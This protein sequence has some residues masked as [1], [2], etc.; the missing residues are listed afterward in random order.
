MNKKIDIYTKRKFIP[1]GCKIT[2]EYFCSTTQSKT[3]KEAKQKVCVKYS[4][5]GT[6]VKTHFSK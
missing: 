6:Q 1:S 5:D 3:C 2:W 4:L